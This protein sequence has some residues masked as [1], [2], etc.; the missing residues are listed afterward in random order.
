MNFS[1]THFAETTKKSWFIWIDFSYAVY[2]FGLKHVAKISMNPLR[3]TWVNE[4]RGGQRH[5]SVQ[6][7][8]LKTRFSIIFGRSNFVSKPI[9]SRSMKWCGKVTRNN[10][11]TGHKCFMENW[12]GWE[13][14][15]Q[16][17]IIRCNSVWFDCWF[18]S[19]KR[20]Y[21]LCIVCWIFFSFNWDVCL[22]LDSFKNC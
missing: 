11:D 22:W 3:N 12:A 10:K 21:L 9:L 5:T 17:T 4:R 7:Q 13:T 19:V 20:C 16:F 8:L 6:Q 2:I 1:A 15:L 18:V 14:N